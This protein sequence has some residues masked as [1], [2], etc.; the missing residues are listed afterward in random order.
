MLSVLKR[1]LPRTALGKRRCL[2]HDRP[3]TILANARAPAAVACP[4]ARQ[5]FTTVSASSGCP[6]LYTGGLGRIPK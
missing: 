2:E 5:R 4:G 3:S 6:S 1:G